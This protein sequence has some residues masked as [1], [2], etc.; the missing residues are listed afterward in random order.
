MI[1][2]VQLQRRAATLLEVIL[3]LPILLILLCG[4]VEFGLL[5][6]NMQKLEIA[7]RTGAS[8]ASQL[9]LP[10][11]PPPA[12][13]VPAAVQDAIT[14]S[15]EGTGI[16]ASDVKIRLEYNYDSSNPNIA[17]TTE[18]L[19]SGLLV[20]P[21]PSVPAV[22]SLGRPYVRVTV[23]AKTT[24]LAPNCLAIFGLDFSNRIS[25]QTTTVR[26]KF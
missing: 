13:P 23:C 3:G 10:L 26:H 22:P 21:A 16:T 19:V 6:S 8:V 20:C 14:S 25:Q 1:T 11:A 4:I 5:F 18:Q 17:G 15:L 9:N 7:S 2:R 12:T 24:D